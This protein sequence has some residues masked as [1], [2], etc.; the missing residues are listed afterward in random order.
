MHVKYGVKNFDTFTKV[1]SLQ[2]KPLGII[3]LKARNHDF[4][5]LYKNDQIPKISD[6]IKLFIFKRC[7][8]KLGDCPFPQ[9][10]FNKSKKMQIN[11][12]IRVKVNFNSSLFT[13][14]AY[15]WETLSFPKPSLEHLSNCF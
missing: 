12:A 15:R 10:Y 5:K 8:N 4:R 9:T 14:L 7:T 3:S 2:N 11:L 1:Q 13:V 6:Y